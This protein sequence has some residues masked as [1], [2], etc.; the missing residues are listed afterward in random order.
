MDSIGKIWSQLINLC[1]DSD[2]VFTDM[3]MQNQFLK[4]YNICFEWQIAFVK[5]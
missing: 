5:D 3:L 1:F 2:L 4:T